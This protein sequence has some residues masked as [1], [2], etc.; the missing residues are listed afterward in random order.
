MSDLRN[1]KC[2]THHISQ[3][4]SSLSFWEVFKTRLRWAFNFWSLG[5]RTKTKSKSGGALRVKQLTFSRLKKSK[6][7]GL[8]R[9][10]PVRG[11]AYNFFFV[12]T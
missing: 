7:I 9:G 10:I 8:D 4:Y 1:R 5:G 2:H 3:I 11:S 6:N 12:L